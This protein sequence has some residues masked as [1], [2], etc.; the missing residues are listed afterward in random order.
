M[1][2][3]CTG[4]VRVLYGCAHWSEQR[5]EIASSMLRSEMQILGEIERMR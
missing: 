1:L 3:G 2:Y 5:T 4:D